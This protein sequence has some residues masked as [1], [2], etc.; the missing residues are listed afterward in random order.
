MEQALLEAI[1]NISANFQAPFLDKHEAAKLLKCHPDTL[2]KWRDQHMEEG[3][4]FFQNPGGE[5]LYN[6]ELI[7]DWMVNRN[8]QAAHLQ[9][10]AVWNSRKLCNQKRRRSA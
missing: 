10:I 1:Q 8:D 2:K 5:Y 6:R 9:A 4:H 3:I 7:I